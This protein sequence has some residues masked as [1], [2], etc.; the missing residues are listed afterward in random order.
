M[1]ERPNSEHVGELMISAGPATVSELEPIQELV[2]NGVV[3]TIVVRDA[4]GNTY[5]LLDLSARWPKI[6]A[7]S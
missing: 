4:A 5:R 2:W 6:L 7:A 3:E 1:T